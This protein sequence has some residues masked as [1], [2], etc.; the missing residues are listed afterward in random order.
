M[1]QR[2]HSSGR[3]GPQ[4]EVQQKTRQ[5]TACFVCLHHRKCRR[6]EDRKEAK[7]K[8]AKGGIEERVEGVGRGTSFPRLQTRRPIRPK[9]SPI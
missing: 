3:N 8:V 2:I 9:P 7:G 4:G 1:S 5:G 6:D